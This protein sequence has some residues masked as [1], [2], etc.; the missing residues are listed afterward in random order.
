M[1]RLPQ[2]GTGLNV[3]G[4]PVDSVE[5]IHHVSSVTHAITNKHKLMIAPQG[6]AGFNPF[7]G[8]QGMDNLYDPNA[9]SDQ[10]GGM[11]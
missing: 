7:A 10:S 1:P 6:M 5:N 9:V 3:A 11:S 4:N 8:M 2:M